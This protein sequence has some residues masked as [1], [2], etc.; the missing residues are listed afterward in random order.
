[1]I[2][3]DKLLS[4][5]GYGSRKEIQYIAW[6]GAITHKGE[7]LKE[8][9]LKVQH[10]DILINGEV[11]DKESLIIVMNK[12]KGFICSHDD[13]GKLI[14][15]LLPLRWQRRNP[16]IATIGRLD[17]DTSGVI[18]LSDDGK[19]NHALSSPKKHIKK[20]YDVE[21]ASPLKGDEI[22]IF[23]SGEMMLK[24]ESKPCLSAKLTIIDAY[25]AKVELYEGKYHQVKRMFAYV[26]NRVVSLHRSQFASI[27]VD[28][29]KEGEFKVIRV[30]DILI[31]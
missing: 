29:L 28:D 11:L 24:G 18:L 19:L 4:N 23:A 12:P 17:V 5:L 2:R 8:V 6:S 26:Q 1:L 16:K 20:I 9:A 7:T 30:E 10:E 14:Y 13:S 3:I 15:S 27:G 25:H 22:E 31:N 21:L